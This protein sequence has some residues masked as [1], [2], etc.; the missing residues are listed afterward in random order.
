MILLLAGCDGG[1]VQVD[2]SGSPTE[3]EDP[4]VPTVVSSDACDSCGGDCLLE[5]LS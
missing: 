3:P 4:T 1:P 2:D 5:E